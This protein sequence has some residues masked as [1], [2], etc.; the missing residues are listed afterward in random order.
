[1]SDTT[2]IGLL[3]ASPERQTFGLTGEQRKNLA[4]AW[5]GSLLEFYEFMVFGFFTVVIG[6]LFFR[7]SSRADVVADWKNTPGAVGIRIIL[8][9][10]AKRE[11]NAQPSVGSRAL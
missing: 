1:M 4:L 8:T 6:K 10:E 7:P 5:L 3:A 2:A 9:Q 11:P